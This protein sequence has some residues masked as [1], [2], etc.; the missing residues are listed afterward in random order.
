[1]SE[2]KIKIDN[3]PFIELFRLG[4]PQS[5]NQRKRKA[6]QILELHLITKKLWNMMSVI[7][8]PTAIGALGMVLKV[9]EGSVRI[10]NRRKNQDHS[11]Y[12][13]V[14]ISQNTEKLLET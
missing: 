9:F 8:I 2:K 1:M 7:V 14:S 5:E 12:S 13:I 6:R 4:G 3:P 11:N 10:G